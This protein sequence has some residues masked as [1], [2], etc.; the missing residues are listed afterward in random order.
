M[1]DGSIPVLAGVALRV[2]SFVGLLK[3][4]TQAD[5]AAAILPERSEPTVSRIVRS[6]DRFL[7]V[8]R[9]NRTG[10]NH[11][12]LRPCA[13]RPLLAAG[14]PEAEIF[15]AERVALSQ[16]RHHQWIVRTFVA[17]TLLNPSLRIVPAWRIQRAN[18]YTNGGRGC[19]PDLLS[20]DPT[21]G[22]STAL[23]I[24]CG[25]ESGIVVRQKARRV[26]DEIDVSGIVLLTVGPRR[27]ASLIRAFEADALPIPVVVLP[28]PKASG[29]QA[30]RELMTLLA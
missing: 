20:F 25:G 29:R 15:I 23:E 14:V 21:S 28:L 2:L 22:R 16:L 3:Q 10:E 5:I 30:I 11:A 4:V 7:E 26:A 6:L 13:K 18:A 24:D 9:F 19:L 8:E 27:I 1:P 17:L 12:R